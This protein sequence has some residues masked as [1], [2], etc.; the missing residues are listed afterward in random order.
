VT[1]IDRGESS[2]LLRPLVVPGVGLDTVGSVAGAIT[3][4]AP[5]FTDA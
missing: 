2:A 5:T 1:R 4:R 3:L